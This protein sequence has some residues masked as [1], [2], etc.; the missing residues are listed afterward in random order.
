MIVSHLV[1][2]ESEQCM[3]ECY[4]TNQFT[5]RLTGAVANHWE[6]RKYSDEEIKTQPLPVKTGFWSTE[7]KCTCGGKFVG[8]CHSDWCDINYK[9]EDELPF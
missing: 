8:N 2:D 7:K 1:W 9:E 5:Y 6:R 4:N 3:V